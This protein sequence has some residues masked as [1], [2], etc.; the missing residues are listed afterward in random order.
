MSVTVYSDVVLDECIFL[1]NGAAGAGTRQNDRSSNQAG[2]VTVNAIRDVT[3]RTYTLGVKAMPV[4]DWMEIE[5]VYEV[6]DAGAFG[7]LILDPKDQFI[8]ATNG[9]LLGQMLGVDNGTFSRGN[10]TPNYVVAKVYK[11]R[12]SS[13]LKARAVTRFVANPV[14]KRGASTVAYGAGA[15][16]IAMGDG[17]TGPQ[18]VT[19]VAD[20]SSTITGMTLGA[21]TVVALS[22]ALSGLVVGGMLWLDGV[23]GTDAAFFNLQAFTITAITGSTYT[24]ALNSTGKSITVSGTGRK[25]PQP[26]ETLTAAAQFYVPVQFGSDDLDWDFIKPDEDV[27]SRLI[28][29]QSVSLVEIREV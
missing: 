4:S 1:A 9:G 22:S 18:V 25:F 20:A 14:I 29:A 28:A 16:Q 7:F 26:S 6:T 11:A 3:L 5:G 24:L 27:D 15:G 23:T 13:R 19:F 17:T 2:Y 12:S 8:D 10:G 21:S